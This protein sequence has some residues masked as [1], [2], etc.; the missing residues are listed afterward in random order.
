MNNHNRNCL[1]PLCYFNNHISRG[2]TVR[3]KKAVRLRNNTLERCREMC[4]KF[5][6]CRHFNFFARRNNTAK[7]EMLR[8]LHSQIFLVGYITG[9]RRCADP[10]DREDDCFEYYKSYKGEILTDVIALTTPQCRQHCKAK[11][12]CWFY[13]HDFR[14]QLCRLFSWIS[15]VHFSSTRVSGNI[16]GD[17]KNDTKRQREHETTKFNNNTLTTVSSGS[18]WVSLSR[19]LLIGTLLS[20]LLVK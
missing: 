12:T 3:N 6:R 10:I 5:K 4:L 19:F 14:L 8:S 1:D 16:I 11:N 2:Y 20:G 13:T 9:T 18:P 15:D 7:C 17:C